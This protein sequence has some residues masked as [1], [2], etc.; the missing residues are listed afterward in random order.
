MAL[1]K[2]ETEYE[3]F[4]RLEAA[5]PSPVEIAFEAAVKKLKPLKPAK[6]KKTP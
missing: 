2:A 1:A 6:E 5:K 3:K 4:R